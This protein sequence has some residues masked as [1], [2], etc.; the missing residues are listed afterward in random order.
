MTRERGLDTC[1][2]PAGI[3]VSSIFIQCLQTLFYFF[4]P[5][6]YFSFPFFYSSFL[7]FS[8]FALSKTSMFET[9]KVCVE[10][11]CNT[12]CPFRFSSLSATIFQHTAHIT[13]IEEMMAVI[14]MEKERT[15]RRKEE[16]KLPYYV[17]CHVINSHVCIKLVKWKCGTDRTL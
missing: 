10:E 14:G 9:F 16:G 8:S 12:L 17:T 3:W 2:F 15:T 1:L 7:P 5:F 13:H 6:F 4:F 11:K